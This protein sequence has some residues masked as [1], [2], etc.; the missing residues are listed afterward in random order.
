M[1]QERLRSAHKIGVAVA[2]ALVVLAALE[3]LLFKAVDS[4]N[5][6][7]MLI[8]NVVDAALILYF[9]MHIAHLWW[10]VEE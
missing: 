3:F 2:V 7:W 1:E 6:P 10:G 4:G 9:F 8:M 5:L